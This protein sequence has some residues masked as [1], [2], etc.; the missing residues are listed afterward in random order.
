[1]PW[2]SYL[3]VANVAVFI[4]EYL[5]RIGHFTSFATS[6][7]YT[8]PLVLI[9]QWGLFYG[10][11]ATDGAHSLFVAGTTFAMVNV[12]FRLV[13]SLYIGEIPNGYNWLGIVCLVTA[14]LLLRVKL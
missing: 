14:L 2:W 9:T 12:G 7:P 6:L 3:L 4:L 8:L 11:R 1:M 5:Y 13:N 10:F